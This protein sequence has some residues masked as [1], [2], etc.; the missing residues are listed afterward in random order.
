MTENKLT[1][2]ED[3]ETVLRELKAA[4]SDHGIVIPSL[5]IR[6]SRAWPGEWR[7]DLGR[8]VAP[9]ILRLASALRA[10]R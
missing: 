6:E 2:R 7:V 9:E 4:L 8:V 1:S 10:P 3:V 5:E